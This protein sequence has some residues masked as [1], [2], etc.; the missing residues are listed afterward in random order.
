MFFSIR[1]TNDVSRSASPA[2][3]QREWI[4]F[5]AQRGRH[6]RIAV[7]RRAGGF[8]L[9]EI[10]IATGILTI[11]LVSIVALFPLAIGY[12][13]DA[14]ESSNSVVIAKSVVESIR[15]GLRNRKRYMPAANGESN[16]YFV[17]RHDGVVDAS[18]G[19]QRDENPSH[20]YY[21]LLP[22]FG[23]SRAFSGGNEAEARW[24]AVESGAKT[25]VYPESDEP[26]NGFGDAQR[27]DDDAND[28]EDGD[29]DPWT[30]SVNKVYRLGQ[31]LVPGGGSSDLLDIEREVLKQYG[32]AFAISPSFFDADVEESRAY[33]PAGK[34]YHV[35]VL[36][37]RTFFKTAETTTPKPIYE[38]DFEVSL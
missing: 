11:G 36:V 22:T 25:F 8:T 17:F 18:P 29:K 13:K 12:G 16:A 14:V 30:L 2:R 19:N 38:I 10:L 15:E 31:S 27:A 21:I 24:R 5:D 35:R 34:L 7:L 32:F 4:P 23:R 37:F 6:R 3:V 28:D 9:L 1:A 26:A 20:D 33:Q